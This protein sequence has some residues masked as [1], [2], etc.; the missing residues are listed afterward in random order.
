MAVRTRAYADT[1]MQHTWPRAGNQSISRKG[2]CPLFQSDN[3]SVDQHVSE[4]KIQREKK[5]ETTQHYNSPHASHPL[6]QNWPASNVLYILLIIL[7]SAW[8]CCKNV[9]MRQGFFFFSA[10]FNG[11]LVYSLSCCSYHS[12]PF[13]NIF[14]TPRRN[15]VIQ[16]PPPPSSQAT[17]DLLLVSVI[18]CSGHFIG[19]ESTT[20][21]LQ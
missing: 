6:L 16:L 17:T 20:G 7:F 8:L 3:F 21:G 2:L 1:Y 11:F 12:N 14:I 9:S 10:P 18:A 15:P 13:Q 19:M 4:L 5:K